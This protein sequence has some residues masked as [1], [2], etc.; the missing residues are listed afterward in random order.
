MAE[1][2]GVVKKDLLCS[3]FP[4]IIRAGSAL[5]LAEV[6][7]HSIMADLH[8]IVAA[9]R[10]QLKDDVGDVFLSWVAVQGVGLAI[11]I[12]FLHALRR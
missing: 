5:L 8:H 3:L 10:M 2:I 11:S 1:G 9:F 12:Q 6:Y 7:I 4:F